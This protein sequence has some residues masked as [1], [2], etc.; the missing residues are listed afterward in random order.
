MKQRKIVVG[1]TGASGSIYAIELI[2]FLLQNNIEIH[3]LVTDAGRLVIGHE[4]L[5]FNSKE[6]MGKNITDLLT[7]LKIDTEDHNLNIHEMNDFAACI[8]SGSYFIDGMVIL[9]CTMGT[10][11]AIANGASKNLLERVADTA[12]KEGRK[13]IIVPRETPLNRIHLKN[14]LSVVDAGATILPAM[15]A[16]YHQPQSIK[17]IVL[18]L[19]GKILDQLMIEHQLFKRWGE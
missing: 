15:P 7:Q 14:M 18:F 10:L 6:L 5:H 9:P 2:K 19:V 1:I 13:L 3:L 8:A 12:L 11:S 4:L 17:D 16:F